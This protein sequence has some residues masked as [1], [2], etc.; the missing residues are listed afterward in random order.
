MNYM[1]LLINLLKIK[2]LMKFKML[3]S[4]NNKHITN[5]IKI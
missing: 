2:V 5:N 1:K 4:K 3:P